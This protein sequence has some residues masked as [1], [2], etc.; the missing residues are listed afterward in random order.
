ML[1]NLL[2]VIVCLCHFGKIIVG[3]FCWNAE[4][5]ELYDS[6]SDSCLCLT[7]EENFS[8]E[9]I[10]DRIDF[11][12]DVRNF[13]ISFEKTFAFLFVSFDLDGELWSKRSEIVGHV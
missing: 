13:L 10:Q 11:W 5:L 9:V 8:L 12:C 3:T 2:H 4:L 7:M 1:A 6:S